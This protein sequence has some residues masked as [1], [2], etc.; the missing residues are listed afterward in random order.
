MRSSLKTSYRTAA[1]AA[2]AL[3]VILLVNA[4]DAKTPAWEPIAAP[5]E[6]VG[7]VQVL[8]LAID[9]SGSMK[10]QTTLTHRAKAA[11]QYAIAETNPCTYAI[12]ILFG[13]EGRVLNERFLCSRHDRQVLLDAV[14]SVTMS[15]ARTDVG[16]L[17]SLLTSIRDA[18][19]DKFGHRGFRLEIQVLTDGQPDPVDRAEKQ[20]FDSILM[21]PTTESKLG[22]GLLLFVA[23]VH[24]VPADGAA[25]APTRAAPAVQG[26]LH[27]IE[28][29][30]VPAAQAEVPEAG[31]NTPGLARHLLLLGIGA[32]L[33][34]LGVF[35]VV[36]RRRAQRA[37]ETV[38]DNTGVSSLA[39][40]VPSKSPIALQITEWHVS[41][42]RERTLAQ[43]PLA[44]RYTPNV[45]I[46][47]GADEGHVLVGLHT[48]GV[49]A[50]LASLT[51]DGRGDGVVVPLDGAF[52]FDGEEVRHQLVFAA[53]HPH[54]LAVGATEVHIEP[55][56]TLPETENELYRRLSESAGETADGDV[57][58]GVPG[59]PTATDSSPLHET[60]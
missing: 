56:S 54:L 33:F 30:P 26:Q 13:T 16:A 40:A 7:P 24:S 12:I 59:T 51:L 52:R 1:V 23:E 8:V 39:A 31:P 11:G 43:G 37:A 53:D 6:V 20:T 41:D 44:V 50:R 27:P 19:S 25:S 49:S 47:I 42:E 55:I 17:E 4:A 29:T 5:A 15:A 46:T 3:S 32:I 38:L 28:P 48:P 9:E 45:P 60:T 21:Q 10:G 2:T 36:A 14:E 35:V 18:V 57:A 34:A 58:T 22:D